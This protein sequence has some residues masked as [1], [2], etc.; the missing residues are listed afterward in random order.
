ME[1]VDHLDENPEKERTNRRGYH[2]K[3]LKTRK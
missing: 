2:S 1:I 3:E